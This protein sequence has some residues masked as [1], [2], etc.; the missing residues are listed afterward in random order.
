M[1]NSQ[2]DNIGVRMRR[3]QNLVIQ[4]LLLD[5]KQGIFTYKALILF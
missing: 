5:E 1:L 4:D 2:S 3:R